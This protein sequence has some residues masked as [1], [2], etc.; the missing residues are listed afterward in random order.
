MPNI[1]HAK[2]KTK[3]QKKLVEEKKMVGGTDS[4][5][6]RNGDEKITAAGAKAEATHGCVWT[7]LLLA[8]FPAFH[9]YGNNG[10]GTGAPR[11]RARHA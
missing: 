3:Q 9:R 10:T 11:A 6:D 2:K 8:S 4:D 7:T 1:E 5:N